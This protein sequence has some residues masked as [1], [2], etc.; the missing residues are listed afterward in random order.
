MGA[1]LFGA[2]SALAQ[3]SGD[4]CELWHEGLVLGVTYKDG[5]KGHGSATVYDLE[6]N[7]IVT[8]YHVIQGRR[9]KDIR[10]WLVTPWNKQERMS[11]LGSPTFT[12][13]CRKEQDICVMKVERLKGKLKGIW[14]SDENLHLMTVALGP[15]LAVARGDAAKVKRRDPLCVCGAQYLETG[16]EPA[17]LFCK[18]TRANTMEREYGGLIPPEKGNDKERI[19]TAEDR[20][21][22][23]GQS[24]GPVFNAA[25]EIIALVT[26]EP[27][28]EKNVKDTYAPVK[29]AESMEPVD[30]KNPDDAQ[31]PPC[32][33]SGTKT[34][35]NLMEEGVWGRQLDATVRVK[36]EGSEYTW[37]PLH[38]AALGNNA[39]EAKLLIE[40]GADVNAK[41]EY[42]ET[43]L[44][45]AAL[46]NAAEVAK[47]LIANGAEV[48][49]IAN[50]A[51][52]N[53]KSPE[54]LTPLHAAALENAAEVAKLL[55]DNG[56]D[57]EAKDNGRWTPLHWAADENAADVVKLLLDNGAEV[58]AKDNDSWT[59][60]YWA[61]EENAAEIA[62]MLIDKGAEV[63][64]KDKY[65]QTPLHAAAGNNAADAAKLLIANSADVNAKGEDGDTPLHW[66]A[67]EN[68]A[69]AAKL[70]IEKGADVNAKSESG[71]TPLHLAAWNNAADAAKLLIANSADVK[72]KDEWD[73]MPLDNAIFQGHD[74]MQSLL[75]HADD[76]EW[77]EEIP[78]IIGVLALIVFSWLPTIIAIRRRHNNKLP[79]FLVNLLL[80][81]TVIG[82][83]VAFIWAWSANV[84][85]PSPS[86]G[87]EESPTN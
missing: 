40:K 54:G 3:E 41:G 82:W 38:E 26:Q 85:D 70:L 48:N 31:S 37:T 5:T 61:A 20:V 55:I 53:A 22:E 69:D 9:A 44:H 1:A 58:K 25:G 80:S 27:N 71:E 16:R 60:L 32:P 42:G 2:A 57:I 29:W 50:G 64:A 67:K 18:P 68:A 23:R 51:E 10:I 65:G 30:C 19:V 4:I 76:S 6:N 63:N 79:I 15:S 45:A 74:E 43:P 47:L 66:A 24:G 33:P 28:D 8:S 14:E 73:D 56:A 83:F 34:E 49:A 62:K 59:P 11:P 35:K 21:S 12:L 75:R 46:E 77:Y 52:V 72:A 13:R 84:K 81:W 78:F 39:A 7:L 36:P 86:A 17:D 87:V